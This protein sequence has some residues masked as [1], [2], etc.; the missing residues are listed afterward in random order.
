MAILSFDDYLASYKQTVQF[1]KTAA[2]TTVAGQ[3]STLK[4]LAGFPAA[5]PYSPS[6]IT[7][8][9]VPVA[10]QTGFP[11]IL[12]IPT[13]TQAYLSRV[14]AFNTV[15][16]QLALF[17]LLFWAGATTIPTS[18]STTITLSSQPSFDARL[19]KAADGVTPDWGSVSIMAWPLTAWSNH[20]HSLSVNYQD[21]NNVGS[22]TPNFSTQN[23]ALG[24]ILPIF[25]N[26][27]NFG[28]RRI[29]SYTLNGAT[30][31]TGSVVVAVVR[32]LWQANT[33]S[34]NQM[35]TWGPDLTGMPEIF[36]ESALFLAGQPTST[37]S[38]LPQVTFE[39]AAK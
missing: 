7:T 1:D 26:A 15:V 3:W 33:P 14:E 39:I 22:A 8:G 5:A 37:S 13:G 6:D 32:K 10:G 21:S 34:I 2:L 24:R 35:L 4:A 19:P 25:F 12:P 16:G 11:V 36:P 30:S 18:G 29:N 31:A 27:G 28:C 38:G 23:R 20:A 9:L 17:D